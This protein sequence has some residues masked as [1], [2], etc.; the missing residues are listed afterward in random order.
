ML[1][2]VI[3]VRGHLVLT[4]LL[5]PLVLRLVVCCVGVIF[6][7]ILEVVVVVIVLV[8]VTVVVGDFVRLVAWQLVYV[9]FN[10]AV[11]SLEL[12]VDLNFIIHIVY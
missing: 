4:E 2:I 9:V 6:F 1:L 12:L 11:F 3:V 5:Q 10:S 8:V 7:F